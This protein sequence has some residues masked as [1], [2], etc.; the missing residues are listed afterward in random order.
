MTAVVKEKVIDT[1]NASNKGESIML[2]EDRDML[3]LLTTSVAVLIGCFVVLVW[4]RS[5]G[6][7]SPKELEIPKIVVPK[8]QLEQEVDDGKKKVTIFFGTQTGTAEGFA[9]VNFS[10]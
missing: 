7:K 9:K 1:V 4:K 8:R 3:L 6:K 2:I 5:S 10:S